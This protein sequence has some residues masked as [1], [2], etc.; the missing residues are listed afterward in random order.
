MGNENES[1]Y[2]LFNVC[3]I[4]SYQMKNNASITNIK[5]L[6]PDFFFLHFI[7]SKD[8]KEGSLAY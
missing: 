4:A 3:H 2:Y 7:I 1:F 6:W 5:E 8:A